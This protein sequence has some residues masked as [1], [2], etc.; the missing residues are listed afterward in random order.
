MPSLHN[1]LVTVE[2][3]EAAPFKIA[4]P[5]SD[6]PFDR[7]RTLFHLIS[8]DEQL[9]FIGTYDQILNYASDMVQKVW[10]W[11]ITS[12]HY[13]WFGT[14]VK[15]TEQEVDGNGNREHNQAGREELGRSSGVTLRAVGRDNQG[16]VGA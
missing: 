12:H 9:S 8:E 4:V 5:I 16:P 13:D 6:P 10:S 7:D 15:S 11:A 2:T 1:L 3:K 14:E